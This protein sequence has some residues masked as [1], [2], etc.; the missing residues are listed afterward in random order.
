MSME[1][2]T[3]EPA[4]RLGDEHARALDLA[5][6]DLAAADASR[7]RQVAHA[8][9]SEHARLFDDCESVRLI[10]WL[11]ALVLAEES[12]PGCDAGAQ[13]PAIHLARLLRERNDYPAD[14]TTW[15]KSVSSNRFL[16]YGSLADRLRG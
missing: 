6:Q 1:V 8:D 16:P 7:L 10:G 11:K 4:A 3:W 15:I 5:I 14:L 2:G 13:S 12:I 9:P